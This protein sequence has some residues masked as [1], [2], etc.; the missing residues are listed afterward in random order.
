MEMFAIHRRDRETLLPIIERECEGGSEI[1]SDEWAAY[2]GVPQ[3]ERRVEFQFSRTRTQTPHFHE[4]F[5]FEVFH[6]LYNNFQRTAIQISRSS[7]CSRIREVQDTFL[8]F[9]N[10]LTIRVNRCVETLFG[11]QGMSNTGI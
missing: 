11:N 5:E 10:S 8:I 7:E 3:A 2:I 1:H 9:M 4:L 6:L